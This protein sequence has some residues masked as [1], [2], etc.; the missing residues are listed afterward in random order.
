MPPVAKPPLFG[1]PML[2]CMGCPFISDDMV[3]EKL[4]PSITLTSPE[5][6]AEVEQDFLLTWE[7]NTFQLDPDAVGLS[8]S[9]GTGHVHIY[10]GDAEKV[11]STE[12][13]M[14]LTGLNAGLQRIE[15]RL[16]GNDHTEL[17]ASDAI[18]VE[19]IS[20]GIPGIEITS[21][22]NYEQVSGAN[23]F[24]VFVKVTNFDLVPEYLGAGETEDQTQGHWHLYLGDF[25]VGASVGE[26]N[27]VPDAS[28]GEHIVRVTL[29]EMDHDLLTNEE[30]THE[31][32]VI[33]Q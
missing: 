30:A 7:V 3:G 19:V 33:A 2:L 29:A 32:T 6:G 16:A 11:T 31:V 1:V 27:T 26:S 18:E 4:Q 13:E 23:G 25:Y 10:V 14:E 22:P 5:D 8:P 17:G 21:P 15:V 20:D 28:L 24:E 9:E 12:T